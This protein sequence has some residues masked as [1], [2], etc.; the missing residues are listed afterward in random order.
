[1]R[2]QR[3]PL[4]KVL[5]VLPKH[6][7]LDIYQRREP[8]GYFDVTKAQMIA[9]LVARPT[10]YMRNTAAWYILLVLGFPAGRLKFILNKIGEGA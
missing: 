7:I 4:K 8:V 9:E 10:S 1:M 2:K 3:N 6:L 5:D